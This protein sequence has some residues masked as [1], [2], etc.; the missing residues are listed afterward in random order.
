M[1][2]PRP[3]LYHRDLLEELRSQ[4]RVLSYPSVASQH[5]LPSLAQ[6]PAWGKERHCQ[7]RLSHGEKRVFLHFSFLSDSLPLICTETL[8][9]PAVAHSSLADLIW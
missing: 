2:R 3:V 6:L 5:V 9:Q 1:R 4:H 8:A 7:S